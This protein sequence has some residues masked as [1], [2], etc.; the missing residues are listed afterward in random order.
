MDLSRFF[1]FSSIDD[2][3]FSDDRLAYFTRWLV[4]S[5]TYGGVFIFF[6]LGF[7]QER[8]AVIAFLA[9]I[10]AY[11]SAARFLQDLYELPDLDMAITYLAA[12]TLFRN[13]RPTI[14]VS[15]G[16]LGVGENQ[17]NLIER[18]GGPGI[19][20]VSPGNLV[21]FEKL[22]GY[23]HVVGRGSHDIN[24]Y[25]F[26]R[27]VISLDDQYCTLEVTAYTVDG[28]R[29]RVKDIN[30]Q[31]KLRGRPTSPT[32]TVM[33]DLDGTAFR[34][35]IRKLS[36]NRLVAENGLL[37][38]E[39]TVK[40][41]VAGAINR[42]INHHSLDQIITPEEGAMDAR[43]AI[44]DVV[45]S[46]EVRDE[47]INIGAQLLPGMQLGAF[48][49]PDTPIDKFRLSRWKEAKKGEI[50]VLEAESDAYQFSRQDAV[51]SQT[52]ADMIRSIITALEDMNLEDARDLDALIQIR[53]AQILDMWSGLYKPKPKQAPDL[54]SILRFRKA[55]EKGENEQEDGNE[56]KPN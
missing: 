30:L 24:R 46:H 48:E 21:L 27:D 51:R 50:K 42:Y 15:S 20:R 2:M 3:L 28:I 8:Y 34:G 54:E 56:K 41:I 17:V 37:T 53:T 6:W 55:Q 7:Q 9:F 13:M 35:A 45:Y 19:V 10:Y 40:G 49:F 11:F 22:T 12:S 16:K 4:L 31:Y 25:E 38:M 26:I 18:I 52:Q 44:K 36:D 23:S 32:T 5:M 14:S 29:V 39:D 43:Q 1:L 33:V 47:L